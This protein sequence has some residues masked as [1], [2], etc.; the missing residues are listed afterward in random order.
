MGV[1]RF[2]FCHELSCRSIGVIRQLSW[3]T[4]RHYTHPSTTN[5]TIR[6]ER[7][8]LSS[9]G[10]P[11]ACTGDSPGIHTSPCI[12]GVESRCPPLGTE[13]AL[14]HPEDPNAPKPS[15]SCGLHGQVGG[16]PTVGH[17]AGPGVGPQDLMYPQ[18]HD[19]TVM[20]L[21]SLWLPVVLHSHLVAPNPLPPRFCC[22]IRGVTSTL[23]PHG[24]TACCTIMS[25]PPRLA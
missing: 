16:L 2:P 20:C 14:K 24:H 5:P 13:P 11:H 6:L 17:K 10:T 18:V 9:G 19:F 7:W 4:Y 22:P 3:Q 23:L 25:A 1:G 8:G 12:A 21:N 15:S